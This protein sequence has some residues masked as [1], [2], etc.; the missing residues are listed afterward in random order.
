MR[1]AFSTV[2]LLLASCGLA[3][4]A[5]APRESAP[6]T[7]S[8]DKAAPTAAA[9]PTA[10]DQR[11]LEFLDRAFDERAAR[12]PETLSGLGIKQDY[13]KLDDYTDADREEGL[14]LAEAQLARMKSA[15]DYD[16]LSPAGQLSWRLAEQIV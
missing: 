2:A 8:S 4:C 7:P 10:E 16:R 13:G 12:S 6:A 1:S 5:T 15:F 14:R 9:V 11:L 3:A